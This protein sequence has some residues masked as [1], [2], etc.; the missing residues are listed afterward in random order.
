[1]ILKE[2][3]LE[4][5]KKDYVLREIFMAMKWFWKIAFNKIHLNTRVSNK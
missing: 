5:K 2:M 3:K 1:M 4:N